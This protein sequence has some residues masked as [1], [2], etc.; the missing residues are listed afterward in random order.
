MEKYGKQLLAIAIIVIF[1]VAGHDVLAQGKGNGKGNHSKHKEHRHDWDDDNF[2]RNHHRQ[3]PPEW[4]PAHGYRHQH[5]ARNYRHVYFPEYNVYFDTQREV[6]IY[7]GRNGWEI[8]ARVP[9]P[10]RQVNF[11]EVAWVALDV[12]NDYPFYDNRAHCRMYGRYQRPSTVV[13]RHSNVYYPNQ[14]HS[15]RG[16]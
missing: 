10:Y 14:H 2:R 6:Y 13:V 11:F 15:C 8:S 1:S 9:L 16:C 4:A 12:Y 7:L 3:G 5:Q